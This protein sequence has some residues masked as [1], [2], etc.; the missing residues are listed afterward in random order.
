MSDTNAER[1]IDVA[2][3]FDV[4]DI[5]TPPEVGSDD[6]IKDLA[7]I[8][9]EEGLRGNFF[10]IGDKA[11]LLR[12]RRRQDV[13][14]SMGPHEVGLHTRSA[15]HPTSP[16][17]VAGKSWQE[18]VELC[19]QQ[20]RE[21]AA[22]I[23]EVF[24]KA[25]TALSGHNVHDTPH[26]LRAAAIMGLPYMYSSA[27]A[28]PLFNLSWYAGALG[29]PFTTNHLTS[30][31]LA[32]FEFDDCEYHADASLTPYPYEVTFQHRLGK[33][34][35]RLDDCIGEG[36]PYLT[37]YLMHPQ[38]LRLT[39]FID[40]FWSPNGV[41][42]PKER[43]GEWGVPRRQRPEDVETALIN[44]RR[45]ARKLAHD[46]RVNIIT[47]SELQKKY[48]Y[49]PPVITKDE[50]I[51]AA[52]DISPSP[53]ILLHPRFSPAELVVG[54]ARAV[55]SEAEQ[56]SIPPEVPRQDVLGPTSSPILYPELQGC[57]SERLVELAKNLLEHV[58]A[59]G[60]LPATLGEPLERVG[61]NHLYH[62]LSEYFLALVEGSPPSE[63]GFHRILPWPDLAEPIAFKFMRFSEWGTNSLDTDVNTT[64]RDGRLQ[65]WTLKPAM[66]RG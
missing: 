12:E 62:E 66:M 58:G 16:E 4:E 9:T 28:P 44:F 57:S 56:G 37:L 40:Y 3:S 1:P 36:Q 54:L 32:Y 5:F 59:T 14:D 11:E 6:S 17:Y 64:F 10:F 2:L 20:E 8:L 29:A 52:I 53:G 50:L 61:V 38:R 31:S 48:G 19:V 13:I 39:E 22:L 41:N 35:E 27:A 46:P 18:A 49:Q 21:G 15:R 63:V 45:L 60:H 34:D 23:T 55:V 43:W 51:Q 26:S 24:G 30:K 7:T 65:T 42:Y 47:M 33:L 25:C